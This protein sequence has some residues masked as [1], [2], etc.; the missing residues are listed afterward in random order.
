MRNV[1]PYVTTGVQWATF[2]CSKNTVGSTDVLFYRLLF[3][4]WAW[5]WISNLPFFQTEPG[6][7]ILLRPYRHTQHDRPDL[8]DDPATFKND[9]VA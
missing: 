5:G 1:R 2:D 7:K 9:P 3:F 4:A 8:T 6:D